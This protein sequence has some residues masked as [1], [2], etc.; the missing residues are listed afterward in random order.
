MPI[1]YSTHPLHPNAARLLDG[2]ADLVIASDL[3]PD[4]LARPMRLFRSA[5]CVS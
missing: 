1:V 3:T 2:H 4:T 5:G